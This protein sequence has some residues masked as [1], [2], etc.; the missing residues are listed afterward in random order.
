MSG[1]RSDT[2]L[3]SREWFG[4][5][6]EPGAAALHIERYTNFG[7]SARELMSDRPIIGIVQTGSDLVPCNRPH[8]ELAQRMRDG[9]REAGGI[10]IEFPV[11]PIQETG[12]R[13][14]AA[15]DRNLQYLSVVEVLYGYP[16]DGVILTTGCDKTTPALLMAAATVNISRPSPST[17]GRCS[18]ATTRAS[19]PAPATSRGKRA[20]WSFRAVQ[21]D[22]YEEYTCRSSPPPTHLAWLLQHDGHGDDDELA[23]RGARHVPARLRRDPRRAQGARAGGVS[24]RQTHRRYGAWD[25]IKPS[26]VMTREAFENAIVINSAIGGSTNAPIHLKAIANHLGVQLENQDWEDL[27][28]DIP[29]MLNS[30]AGGRVSRRRLPPCRRAAGGDQSAAGKGQAAASER[31]DGER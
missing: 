17:A 7:I 11:H 12:K 13:P 19:W 4:D 25:D 24:D 23:R 22:G 20:S 28:W 18:T 8:V 29:L 5:L 14:T 2:K 6:S 16:I 10:P 26:D 21:I 9:I 31:Y 1:K 3:R 30:A 27:G 15:V